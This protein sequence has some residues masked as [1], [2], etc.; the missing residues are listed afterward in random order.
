[1]GM[2]DGKRVLIIGVSGGI[3][4]SCAEKCL[5]EGAAVCGTFRNE[6]ERLAELSEKYGER[7]S[8]ARVDLS[9]TEKIGTEIK[10]ALRKLKGV[11]AMINAA[12]TVCSELIFSARRGNFE[13]V[14]SCNLTAAFLAVQSVIVPMSAGG[15]SIINISSVFGLKGGT[16]Q[17]GYCASKAGLIGL[18]KAAAAELAPKIRVNAVA[19][20][21]IETAMTAGFEEEYRKKCVEKIPMKRFGT[22][23]ET[24]DL[25]VFLAS[26]KSKYITGQTFVIDGGMSL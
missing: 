9:E 13:K 6:N 21:Y 23:E 7:F 8:L 12:G 14:I 24:A 5:E 4:F 17:A 18:T 25:C 15:G 11:D 1:M 26:D 10:A 19:P 3:G 16:G 20:G 22:P 2:L